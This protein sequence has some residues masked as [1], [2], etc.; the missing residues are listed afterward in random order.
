LAIPAVIRLGG[1]FE[2]KA[3]EILATY[4]QDLPGAV[5]GYGRDDAPE[6]CAARLEELVGRNP[7]LGHE[8]RP[9]VETPAPPNAYAFDTLTGRLSFDHRKCPDCKTK[10][11]VTACAPGILKLQAG[12]P[13]LA[14]SA[15]AAKKGKCS[16]CL[17]CEIFC[18][19]HEFDAIIAHLPIP[20]LREYRERVIA[21]AKA[22]G[23]AGKSAN[24]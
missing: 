12:F 6:F 10:G 22:A 5:E 11:C 16:E 4:L 23:P 21:E 7:E 20:G 1:N 8:V 17:A 14:I 19:F 15:E 18:K 13:V 9:L 24:G 3:I 2:E